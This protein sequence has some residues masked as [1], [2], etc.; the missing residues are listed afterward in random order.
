MTLSLQ[1]VTNAIVIVALVAFVGYR[2]MTWRAVDPGR[3]WRLPAI[4]AIVGLV[5]LG[6]MT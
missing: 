1:L 6:S 2:Q 3:M 5:T 4:L